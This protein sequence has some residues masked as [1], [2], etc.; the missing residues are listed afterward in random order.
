MANNGVI[1]NAVIEV[2]VDASR[3]KSGMDTAAT[4]AKSEASKIAAGTEK[5]GISA[6]KQLSDFTG[7]VSRIAAALGTFYTFLRIGRQIGD[8]LESGAQKAQKFANS[9]DTRN[10]SDALSKVNA[11]I[12]RL[13]ASLSGYQQ[14]RA[15]FGYVETLLEGDNPTGLQDQIDQL[16]K[17]SAVL[18]QF[19]NSKTRKSKDAAAKERE[20]AELKATRNIT[21]ATNREADAAYLRNLEGI[22]RINEEERQ[23]IQD[24]AE[25]RKLSQDAEY[26]R[27]LDALDFENK[28]YFM[29]QRRTLEKEKQA[30][31]DEERQRKQEEA[32]KQAEESARQLQKIQDESNKRAED[33]LRRQQDL[34]NA[35]N[36]IKQSSIDRT[37]GLVTSI[38]NLN[39]IAARI[40]QGVRGL[41]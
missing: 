3:I 16:R 40:E 41:R 20:D 24:I 19:E 7:G 23:S 25:R 4:A 18:Q 9:L 32:D 34:V 30:K 12:A 39:Q 37:A 38:E 6:K 10:S 31:I 13:E 35:I 36:G 1:G 27:A 14:S 22:D 8:M 5:V 33:S 28:L 21:E 11:E 15:G 17:L 2:T 26:Q 29:E